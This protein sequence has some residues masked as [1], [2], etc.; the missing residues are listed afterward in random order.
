MRHTPL[1]K[2]YFPITESSRRNHKNTVKSPRYDC[3]SLTNNDINSKR[4]ESVRIKFETLQETTKRHT[5]NDEYEKFVAA[6]IEAEA[7]CILTKSRA[8]FRV[9]SVR[10]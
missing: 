2:E 1:L 8:K 5:P 3:Y 4:K 7:E 6:H 9:L 10:E